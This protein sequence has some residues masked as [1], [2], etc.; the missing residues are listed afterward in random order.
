MLA[1]IL[2][3]LQLLAVL[4]A[5]GIALALVAWRGWSPF[6]AIPAGIAAIEGLHVAVLGAEFIFVARDARGR[7]AGDGLDIV[8]PPRGWESWPAVRAWLGEIAASLRAFFHAQVWFGDRRL[9][10]A[11]GAQR[12]PVL[13]VHGY[14][15]NRAIWRP[16]AAEL[17][18][19]GHPVDS[20]NLEPVFGSI[21]D[22]VPTIAARVDR[23]RERWGCA[24]VAIVAHSMGGLA[25]RAYLRAAGPA[26]IARTV[27]L[28]TPHNGT[29]SAFRGVGHN[30]R[31]MRPGSAWLGALAASESTA[32]NQ[33]VTVI[34][35][36]HDNILV[37]ALPQTLP[38]AR[39]IAFAGLGHVELVY[40]A[41]V[42]QAVIAEL[43]ALGPGDW[44]GGAL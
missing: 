12:I 25:A 21:D 8:P 17:A 40:A 20:V 44:R 23:L 1:R 16:F 2:R 27:T 30:A 3:S 15:C 18:A 35:S 26:P 32:T 39:T 41:T 43:D 22:Y 10:S 4:G 33:R 14:F 13:F 37:P 29:R 31:Q 7:R 36:L 24:Q 6:W 19:R 38:G 34:L 5:A 28:G 9:P 42:R 11:A